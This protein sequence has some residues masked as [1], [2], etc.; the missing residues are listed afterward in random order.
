M[1]PRRRLASLALTA[2]A[3]MIVSCGAASGPT[4]SSTGTPTTAPSFT[5]TPTTTPVPSSTAAASSNELTALAAQVYPHCTPATCAAAGSMFTTCD[6]GS[7]GSDVFASCPLTPRLA[8]QLEAVAASVV[9]APDP[10]GGGQDPEWT[11]ETFVATPSSTGGVVQV[12]LGFGQGNPEKHDLVV[13]LSGSQLLVDDI[14]CTGSD[15]ASGDAYADG[16]VARSPCST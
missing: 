6:A 1:S 14:Y 10:L 2:V 8:A 5:P 9:S 13:I 3:M 7:S 16:W 11:T 15:P 12:T 4:S